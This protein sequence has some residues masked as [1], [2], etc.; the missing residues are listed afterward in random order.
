[1]L[2]NEEIRKFLHLIMNEKSELKKLILNKTKIIELY[3]I[4][5]PFEHDLKFF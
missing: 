4:N 2:G 3:L 5:I 1:M